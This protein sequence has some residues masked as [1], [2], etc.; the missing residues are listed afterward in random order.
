MKLEYKL[1]HKESEASNDEEESDKSEEEAEEI[2]KHKM[3]KVKH[4]FIDS[5][6]P[7][8]VRTEQVSD[9]RPGRVFV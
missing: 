7:F 8:E 5:V 1:K 6:A 3:K 4:H 2:E 9:L